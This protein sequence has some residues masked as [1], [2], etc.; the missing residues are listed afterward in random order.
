MDKLHLVERK[1]CLT[2]L[3]IAGVTL[4]FMLV[5]TVCNVVLRAFGKPVVGDFEIISFL[6]AIVVSFSLPYTSMIKGHV[7][8]DLLLEKLS[9]SASCRFQVV[10]RIVSVALFAWIGWNFCIMSTDLMHSGELTP[11][12]RVP[13]YPI[14]FGVAFCCLIQCFVLVVQ[15]GEVVGG[16]HE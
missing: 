15:I 13:Y 1:L 6:G 4:A 11:V 3:A 8:V 14:C 16:R 12:F 10:T 5:F 7:I 9:K 2:L